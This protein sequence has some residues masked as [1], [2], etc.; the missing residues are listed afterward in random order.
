[1][2]ADRDL[3]AQ[4]RNALEALRD[5]D[6]GVA[7]AMGEAL[8]RKIATRTLHAGESD[9]YDAWTDGDRAIWIERK[10]LDAAGASGA[11]GMLTVIM[12]LIHEYLHDTS[13]AG[14]HAH[15][16]AFVQDFHN[17]VIDA[18]AGIQD[19]L[20]MALSYLH[21]NNRKRKSRSTAVLLDHLTP[22]D[23]P[24]IQRAAA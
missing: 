18:G 3:S 11:P 4:E 2:V 19:T 10:K 9:A 15:D 7:R 8:G 21:T 23:A 24:L 14:S 16:E 6:T 5:I 13:D 20:R 17:A 12:L 1:V 22:S